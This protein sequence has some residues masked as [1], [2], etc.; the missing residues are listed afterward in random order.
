MSPPDLAVV[1]TIVAE[2]RAA[3]GLPPKVAEPAVL[4]KVATLLTQR[5]PLA[6]NEEASGLLDV[7]ASVGRRDNDLGCPDGTQ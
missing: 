7:H 5:R 6:A 3:Q 4:A 2:T 1:A